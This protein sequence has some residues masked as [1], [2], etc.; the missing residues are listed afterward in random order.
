MRGNSV[1]RKRETILPLFLRI[2]LVLSPRPTTAAFLFLFYFS[3]V[4]ATSP[5]FV[6]SSIIPGT[7]FE[8]ERPTNVFLY[9]GAVWYF[10]TS[11]GPNGSARPTPAP[12][13]SHGR[14]LALAEK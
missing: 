3:V 9:H 6:C 1:A 4:R 12:P 14:L 10:I 8:A 11:S 7:L 5:L 2:W 13:A